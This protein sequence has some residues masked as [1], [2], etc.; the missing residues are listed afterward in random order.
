MR[1]EQSPI[2]FLRKSAATALLTIAIAGCGNSTAPTP[3]SAYEHSPSSTPTQA[4][5]ETIAPAPTE[6]PTLEI[7]PTPTLAPTPTQAPTADPNVKCDPRLVPDSQTIVPFNSELPKDFELHVPILEYHLIDTLSGGIAQTDNAAA[8]SSL[9]VTP[10]NFRQQMKLL[11][12]NGWHT[13]TMAGLAK[14]WV[15]RTPLDAKTFVVTFDDG[16]RDGY[17]NAVPILA[18][19]GFVGT[20]YDVAGRS[21]GATLHPI[22]NGKPSPILTA[23][24]L[25]EMTASGNDIGNHSFSHDGK[26]TKQQADSEIDKASEYIASVT[27]FWPATTAYPFGYASVYNDAVNKCGMIFGLVQQ[28]HD[29]PDDWIAQA[30]ERYDNRLAIPRVKV[31]SSITKEFLLY[32][33]THLNQQLAAAKTPVPIE[34]PTINPTEKPTV[35]PTAGPTASPTEGPTIAPTEKPTAV[36]TASPIESPIAIFDRRKNEELFAA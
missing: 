8:M 19:F 6:T 31:Y 27:G 25:N 14:A 30:I 9:V 17:V 7:T 10:E 15:N 1:H 4:P 20:F 22:V 23:S 33:L 32:E 5:T 24:E 21:S 36:P 26:K 18:E 3:S 29:K 16:Y 13:I 12:E 28:P 11:H 35:S 34:S 2:H